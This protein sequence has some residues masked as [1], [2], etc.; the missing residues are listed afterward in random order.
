MKGKCI[1]CGGQVE[2]KKTA[3]KGDI[4]FCLDCDAELEVI[5][6][7]PLKFSW[8]KEEDYYEDYDDDYDD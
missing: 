5:G 3:R 6:T 7:N 8:P 1:M 2:V 4:V